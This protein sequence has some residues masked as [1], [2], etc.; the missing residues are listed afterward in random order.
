MK[1]TE[2]K[3][4]IVKKISNP[5]EGKG[6]HYLINAKPHAPAKMIRAGVT[7]CSNRC[8]RKF[9]LAFPSLDPTSKKLYTFTTMTQGSNYLANRSK[10]INTD[11][12]KDAETPAFNTIAA[13]IKSPV[14]HGNICNTMQGFGRKGK[15]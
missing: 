2:T 15:R 13:G 9:G 11:I 5:W 6:C 1:K 8:A 7:F 12:K 3:E 4:E 14:Q 10:A